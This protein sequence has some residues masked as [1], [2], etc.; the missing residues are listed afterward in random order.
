MNISKTYL[1]SLSSGDEIIH[2]TMDSIDPIFVI[3]SINELNNGD[4]YLSEFCRDFRYS[5]DANNQVHGKY[6]DLVSNR[7]V[8]FEINEIKSLTKA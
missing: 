1:I 2:A 5:S 6:F 3:E 4:I 8:T 7:D